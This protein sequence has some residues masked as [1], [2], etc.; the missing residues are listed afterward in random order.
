M[1]ISEGVRAL[2]RAWVPR[3]ILRRVRA[4]SIPAHGVVDLGDLRRTRPISRHFGFDR[5]LPIDRWFIERFLA[6]HAADVRGRVLE[7]GDAIYTRRFGGDRVVHSDVLHVSPDAPEA[8]IVADLANAQAIPSGSFDC[9]ILTQTLHLIYD[10][11][12]AISTLQR[13]LAPGGVLLATVPGISQIERG[14]WGA[15]W[16]WSFTVASMVRRFGESFRPSDVA[17]RSHGNVLVA[18]G[19]LEGLAADELTDKERLAPDDAYPVLITIRATKPPL[20]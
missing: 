3:S 7:V 8:T 11:P 2:V 4:G 19:F 14:E 16:Y 1:T 15:T 13:I 10:V 12:A 5:G 17:V 18:I 9:V 20:P 6:A